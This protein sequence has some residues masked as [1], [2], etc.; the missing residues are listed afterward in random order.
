MIRRFNRI[1]G[2]PVTYLI[3]WWAP[4]TC[5]SII[6]FSIGI[7]TWNKLHDEQGSGRR[8]FRSIVICLSVLAVVPPWYGA[9]TSYK[10]HT[11]IISQL[12]TTTRLAHASAITTKTFDLDAKAQGQLAEVIHSLGDPPRVLRLT[13][14]QGGEPNVRLCDELTR[15][16]Q[17]AH[18]PVVEQSNAPM[19]TSGDFTPRPRTSP[20]EIYTGKTDN[21]FGQSL[22]RALVNIG[23]RAQALLND[24]EASP[25]WSINLYYL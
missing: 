24:D 22:A 9:W 23:L 15:S 1:N 5:S 25:D 2:V 17:L 8:P 12:E 10:D 16:L 3:P 14:F 18:W 11:A 6:V 4:P 13:C 7:I 21:R 20:V 19:A